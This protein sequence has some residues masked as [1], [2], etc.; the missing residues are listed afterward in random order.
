V[1]V[2]ARTRLTKAMLAD[3]TPGRDGIRR[4]KK[5]GRLVQ[6]N[7]QMWR[8]QIRTAAHDIPLMVNVETIV[9]PHTLVPASYHIYTRNYSKVKVD[10]FESFRA[11]TILTIPFRIQDHLPKAP[12]LDQFKNLL[13]FVG[14][15]LGLSPWGN[16]FGYGRFELLDVETSEKINHEQSA[17]QVSGGIDST[18]GAVRRLCTDANHPDDRP[19]DTEKSC[20]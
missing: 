5:E 15:W 14:T 6:V 8:G 4:F 17:I 7:E 20:S 10:Q 19:A 18:Q 9:P 13:S 2:I 1:L 11:G 3:S 12:T 16:K